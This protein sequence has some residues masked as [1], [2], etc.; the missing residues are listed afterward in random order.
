MFIPSDVLLRQLGPGGFVR[1]YLHRLEVG[2]R[3]KQEGYH[4]SRASFV[5]VVATHDRLAPVHA[6]I[7]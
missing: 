7:P 3:L 6:C 1:L 5:V 2:F 4:H